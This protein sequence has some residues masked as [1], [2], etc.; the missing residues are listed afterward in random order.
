MDAQATYGIL[1]ILNEDGNYLSFVGPMTSDFTTFSIVDETTNDSFTFEM[2]DADGGAYL[3]DAGDAGQI[4]IAPVP[5]EE[6]FEALAEIDAKGT[7]VN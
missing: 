1:V 7:A 4:V 2:T 3:F 5:V 6:V